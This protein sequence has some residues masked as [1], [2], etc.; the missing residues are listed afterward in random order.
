MIRRKYPSKT[1]LEVK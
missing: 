1:T